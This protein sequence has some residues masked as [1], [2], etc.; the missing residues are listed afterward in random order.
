MTPGPDGGTQA[1]ALI[2]HW[3]G[4]VGP[5]SAGIAASDLALDATGTFTFTSGVLV[6]TSFSEYGV[7]RTYDGQYAISGDKVAF[8][9]MT[10]HKLETNNVRVGEIGDQEIWR[11]T[12]TEGTPYTPPDREYSFAIE[13]RNGQRTAI[14]RPTDGATEPKDL[15]GLAAPSDKTDEEL[16]FYSS[17]I[18]KKL[19][20]TIGDVVVVNEDISTDQ[21]WTA[22]KIYK[23]CPPAR[24]STASVPLH[25]RA[26]LTIQP[27]TV[28]RAVNGA[29]LAVSQNG[30]IMANGA[31]D[32]PITF[33]LSD[34]L[35]DNP[36][37]A[38]KQWNGIRMDGSW[39]NLDGGMW[40]GTQELSLSYCDVRGAVVGVY[41]DG[42]NVRID[43]CAFTG[44]EIGLALAYEKGN[45]STPPSTAS[46]QHCTFQ[47]NRVPVAI[48]G[49]VSFD[50]TN[51]FPPPGGIPNYHDGIYVLNKGNIETPVTWSNADVPYV[52]CQDTYLGPDANDP[53][54][55]PAEALAKVPDY[56]DT[57]TSFWISDAPAGSLTLADGVALKFRSRGACEDGCDE[58][59]DPYLGILGDG[60]DPST[61]LK[62]WE[63][64]TFTIYSDDATKGD[65]D[66]VT[67]P[68]DA[69][70][71]YWNGIYHYAADGFTHE[72]LTGPNVKYA[73]HH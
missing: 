55:S 69:S 57:A 11:R 71:A 49:N 4:Q 15:F 44:N 8:R 39:H 31:S 24:A 18:L 22:D 30:R 28:I 13:I 32:K 7:F 65:T 52:I 42:G 64:A 35:G 33:A 26:A 61:A 45:T 19:G 10:A 56:G 62:N 23:I 6:V 27:G 16:D 38:K 40:N 14:F 1:N 2:G 12:R 72:Y 5:T 51:A 25:L 20:D 36:T 47:G 50:G 21:T 67:V 73:A 60:R 70:Q 66:R 37:S 53:T 29:E 54:Y 43:H 9:G 46:V 17:D 41:A 59:L 34:D 63:G 68:L 3:H 58:M 48:D